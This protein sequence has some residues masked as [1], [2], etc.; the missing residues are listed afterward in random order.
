VEDLDASRS[1]YHLVFGL[2]VH[3]ADNDS[4]FFRSG[5][6]MVNLLTE[7][8]A[9]EVIAPATP[10]PAGAGANLQLTINVDDVDG[11]CAELSRRGVEL[12][13]GPIDRP[14]GI[15]TASFVDPWRHIW[16]T[17]SYSSELVSVL[18]SPQGQ[19]RTGAFEVRRS[20]AIARAS[21]RR[22]VYHVP[23]KCPFWGEDR[24]AGMSFNAGAT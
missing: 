15:R 21:S 17:L 22:C 10:S 20:Q 24:T 7:A 11:T 3:F 13:N 1:F 19:A 5:D 18:S 23:M 14:W 12:L 6:L 4:V 9:P 8:A 16:E 2:P